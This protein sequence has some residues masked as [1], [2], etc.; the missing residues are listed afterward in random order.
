MRTGQL[1]AATVGMWCVGAWAAVP[2]PADAVETVV[3]VRVTTAGGAVQ[4]SAVRIGPR[5]LVT[6][7]HV[8]AGASRIEITG[9]SGVSPARLERESIDRDICVIGTTDESTVARSGRPYLGQRVY[10]VGFPANAG[11]TVTEGY[12]VALHHHDGAQV[13]QTSAPFDYG[14][15]GGGLFDE[16]GRLVG[17]LAFK[18]R[19]GGRFHFALPLEW[20]NDEAAVP[21]R[22][23]SSKVPFWRARSSELPAFLRAAALEAAS[24]HLTAVELGRMVPDA[25]VVSAPR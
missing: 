6:N 25:A 22:T 4:G 16:E 23:A 21:P 13:I 5:K 20:F 17:I 14:A 7:C 9:Q 2:P 8:I 24:S 10:A 11:L 1:I 12:V 19:V 15:S 18:A 3:A